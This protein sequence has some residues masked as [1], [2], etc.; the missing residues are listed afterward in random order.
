MLC[1]QAIDADPTSADY[2]NGLGVALLRS[3]RY[4]EAEHYFSKALHMTP[5]H[6]SALENIAQLEHIKHQLALFKATKERQPRHLLMCPLQYRWEDL[7]DTLQVKKKGILMKPFVV[8]SPKPVK[9]FKLDSKTNNAQNA[10]SNADGYKFK[11]KNA[12]IKAYSVRKEAFSQLTDLSKRYGHSVVDYYPY[13]M[14]H[15]AVRP[16]F[17]TMAESLSYLSD[18][19]L[20]NYKS[21]Y[22]VPKHE[23]E[24]Q[25]MRNN[26]TGQ[27]LQWNLDH[28]SWHQVLSD[29]NFHVPEALDDR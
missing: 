8:R 9:P 17:L 13:G 12:T 5:H 1:R 29:A 26:H 16:Y 15:S 25:L 23:K 21:R 18:K 24:W 19:E 6:P 22:F 4:D 28:D 2:L 10:K 14:T 20:F 11:A 3:K 27:Y 7:H